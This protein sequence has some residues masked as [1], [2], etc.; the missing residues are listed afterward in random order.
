MKR[1]FSVI[2]TEEKETLTKLSEEFPSRKRMKVIATSVDR[3]DICV[4]INHDKDEQVK[5]NCNMMKYEKIK[6]KIKIKEIGSILK[7][8]QIEGI[9]FIFDNCI[10]RYDVKEEIKDGLGC[11]IAHVMGLGKTFTAIGFIECYLFYKMGKYVIIVCPVNVIKMWEKECNK[12]INEY[13]EIKLYCINK[14]R[15]HKDILEW[16]KKGGILII[17]FERLRSILLN[18]NNINICT[19][20]IN[21]CDLLI[22]DEGHRLKNETNFLWKAMNKINTKRRVILTGTPLQNNLDEYWSMINFIRPNYLKS[23]KQFQIQFTIPIQNGYKLLYPKQMQL[24]QQK[25]FILHNLLKSFVHRKTYYS[26]DIK[27]QFQLPIKYDWTIQLSLTPCQQFLYQFLIK[28]QI[29][30]ESILD[31][32]HK[33]VKVYNHP[34]L[35]LCTTKD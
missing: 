25:C 19:T 10:E 35:F 21:D 13:E 6:I 29:Y 2:E 24:I 22:V 31:I 30:N 15:K 17:G 32:Y 5:V 9:R 18:K 26:P 3:S 4:N 14:D 11:I 8:H 20:I 27:Q 34:D 28:Q 1:A 23:K 7:L 33:L 16:N 12:W